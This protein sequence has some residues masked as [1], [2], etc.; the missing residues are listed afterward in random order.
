MAGD[1]TPKEKEKTKAMINK[2]RNISQAYILIHSAI[3]GLNGYLDFVLNFLKIIKYPQSREEAK[4]KLQE[5]SDMITNIPNESDNFFSYPEK[6]RTIDLKRTFDMLVIVG[7]L[8]HQEKKLKRAIEGDDFDTRM[9]KALTFGQLLH[10]KRKNACFFNFTFDIKGCFFYKD[11]LEC[12]KLSNYLKHNGD[13]SLKKLHNANPELFSKFDS[14]RG[15]GEGYDV[16]IYKGDLIRYAKAFGVFWM[17][18]FDNIEAFSGDS[19]CKVYSNARKSLGKLKGAI[20]H[21]SRH[22]DNIIAENHQ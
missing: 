20:L 15:K 14:I 12:N 8:H 13:D 21:E 5:E 16:V 7:L 9:P 6:L 10:E 11:I 4:I 3:A 19:S 18:L 2:Y 1:F 22:L 17:Y